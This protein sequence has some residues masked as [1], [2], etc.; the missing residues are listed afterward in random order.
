MPD[1]STTLDEVRRL[2]REIHGLWTLVCK[3]DD[4]ATPISDMN[5]VSLVDLV[6]SASLMLEQLGREIERGREEVRLALR[7]GHDSTFVYVGRRPVPGSQSASKYRLRHAP[8]EG[9]VE[10]V[11]LDSMQTVLVAGP[12]RSTWP[13]SAIMYELL[14]SLVTELRDARN[15]A[16]RYGDRVKEHERR[17]GRIRGIAE[18]LDG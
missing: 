11:D 7:D 18:G 1:L 12:S 6:G 15:E 16:L 2:H 14:A 13:S 3:E 9:L 10:A 5:G 8:D 17:L 4:E